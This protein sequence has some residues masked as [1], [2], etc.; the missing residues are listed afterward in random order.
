[1]SLDCKSLLYYFLHHSEIYCNSV[2]TLRGELDSASHMPRRIEKPLLLPQ[3][4]NI[5]S[6]SLKQ[7]TWPCSF[8]QATIKYNLT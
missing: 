4:T 1:M 8:L 2:D 5:M 3:L 7:G 6:T